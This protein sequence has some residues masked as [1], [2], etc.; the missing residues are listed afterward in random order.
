MLVHDFI[1]RVAARKLRT[2]LDDAGTEG[3]YLFLHDSHD[4]DLASAIARRVAADVGPTAEVEVLINPRLVAGEVA[5]AHVT[6]RS[7]AYV[8]NRARPELRLSVCCIPSEEA[9]Q[10][11]ATTRH[12]GRLD[13]AWFV[14]DVAP[15][16]EEA[17]PASGMLVREQLSNVIHGL[18]QARE[19]VDLGMLGTFVL[20][21]ARRIEVDGTK[22]DTAV[23]EAMPSLRL[24]R[25]GGDPKLRISEDADCSRQFFR[26]AYAVQPFLFCRDRDEPFNRNEMLKRLE[27]ARTDG[28][29]TPL[30][31][32]AIERLVRDKSVGIEPWTDTQQAAAEVPW[33]E[34]EPFVG[35]AKRK[36]KPRLGEETLD[37]LRRRSPD[38]VTKD[39]LGLL[40]TVADAN[41]VATRQLDEFYAEHASLLQSAPQLAKKWERLVFRKPIEHEDLL[42]GLLLLAER[43]HPDGDEEGEDQESTRILV[44]RLRNSRRQDFWQRDTNTRIARYLRDRYRGLP[45]MLAPRVLLD[46]GLCWSEEWDGETTVVSVSKQ[47]VELEFEAF[48]VREAD[49][50]AALASRLHVGST[51]RAKFIWKPKVDSVGLSFPEDLRWLQGPAASEVPL[52]TGEIQQ[53]VIGRHKTSFVADIGRRATIRDVFGQSGGTLANVGESDWRMDASF[54]AGLT[55]LEVGGILTAAQ[56]SEIRGSFDAFREAYGN[57]VADLLRGAGLGSDHLIEQAERF[58]RLFATLSA[59][60]TQEVCFEHLWRPMLRIGVIT[61]EGAEH[62]AAIVAGWQPL[63]LAEAAA[64]ARQFRAMIYAMLEGTADDRTGLR[65]FVRDAGENLSR[66]YYADVALS[67]RSPK[68]TYTILSE[69]AA[70][71]GCSLLRSIDGAKSAMAGEPTDKAVRAYSRVAERYLDLRPHERAGFSTVILNAESEDLPLGIARELATWID[72]DGEIRC[73]LIVSDDDPM[74]LR[75]SYEDQNRRITLDFEDGLAGEATRSFLSRLRVG[76]VPPERLKADGGPKGHDIVVLQD[77]VAKNSAVRWRREDDRPRDLDLVTFVPTRQSRRK[78]FKLGDTTTGL[79]LT[80]PVQPTAARSYVNALHDM[81]IRE[82]TSRGSSWLPLQEVEFGANNVKAVLDTAH[83]YANWVMT[84][85]RVADRRLIGTRSDRRI[86]QYF[87]V[88]GSVHNV[89]VSAELTADEL[90]GKL[91]EDIETIVPGADKAMR[92][93]I[94]KEVYE[95]AAA[96]SGGLIMRGVQWTNYARDCLGLVLSQREIEALLGSDGSSLTGWFHLDDYRGWLEL[97]GEI[98]DLLAVNFHVRDGKPTIRLV[99]AEAK[100]VATAALSTQRT[101]SL[102]QLQRTFGAI[103]HRF[104]G[105]P[106]RMDAEIWRSRLSDMILEHME[107]FE[108]V[109]GVAQDRWIEDLRSASTPIEVTGHSMIFAYDAN[110]I[111]GV[112]CSVPDEAK[113]LEGRS[114]IAQWTFPAN[115]T[116]NAV[117]ALLNVQAPTTIHV[118]AAWPPFAPLVTDGAD[119]VAPM[120]QDHAPAPDLEPYVPSTA[121]NDGDWVKPD[122]ETPSARIGIAETD[123]ADASIV[124]GV[125]GEA[126]VPVAHELP[127]NPLVWTDGMRETLS[128]MTRRADDAEARQ[129]LQEQVD[130]LRSALQAEGVSAP[131]RSSRL[132][133]NT[134]LVYV[135]ARELTVAWL[136]RKRTYLL[137][138]YGIQINR[139]EPRPGMIGIGIRRPKRSTMS[140]ADAWLRRVPTSSDEAAKRFAPLLGEKEDDGSLCYLPLADHINDQQKAAPH[141]LISGSTGSGKGILLTNIILD[142]CAMNAPD[143]LDLYLIDPKLGLDYAWT[144]MLPHL[145][146]GIVGDQAEAVALLHR[147][148]D[149]MERRYELITGR[150]CRNI[151]HY[152]DRVEPAARLS[153]IVI[154]F[155]EVANWMQDDDFKEGVESVLNKI[156]TMARAAGFHLFMV[157]QRA[158]VQVMTMQLRN[159][160]GNKLILRLG[161][162]GSS[163][164]ALGEKGAERLLGGGHMVAKL[165]TDEKIYLQVPF[166]SEREVEIL[167]AAI[168]RSWSSVRHEEAAE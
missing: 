63:R 100:Y 140:I 35:G 12:N 123:S 108:H 133:P 56:A 155:D 135:E 119:D 93:R 107:P 111:Q 7:V 148:V 75:Q 139:V 82:T 168:A 157:Y 106:G 136:E 131:I 145:K 165:D 159:N 41:S 59:H 13:A 96:I 36:V 149:E 25:N 92:T 14:R 95:R 99:V 89:V 62:P 4:A 130:A 65:Q 160:L 86:I 120:Q 113:E 53:H 1:G 105:Q 42:V 28:S 27:V 98:A 84:Y 103:E 134:G 6:E 125:G 38:A 21:V 3:R 163:R 57:A 19:I 153:R 40:K 164:I 55:E 61:V 77:V 37:F 45:E 44:I 101:K 18:L 26:Q 52:V 138:R 151:D 141:T 47:A 152:N 91:Q 132:T 15:W 142:L 137:T 156:A 97:D 71:T 118:P 43:A 22:V 58:G 72:R 158:D 117:R 124:E 73:D 11:E 54:L 17:L 34:I 110:D 94:L 162:E 102:G 68:G 114:R 2:I 88:P 121:M 9:R 147:L 104:G 150:G 64:K 90:G 23:R 29:I 79:Y 78:P 39:T 51:G 83:G 128:T 49:L 20:D 31:A 161:D 24:S 69:V 144:Q 167:A 81:E 32:E 67:A 143:D 80:A 87:S 48:L 74:R 46:C 5:P 115:R 112:Q 129:W 146:S 30:A 70:S 109:G 154:I 166:V 50:E 85:D 60:A 126:T 33:P 66:T 16:S 122:G 127:G 76:I 10:I 116:A 8:R